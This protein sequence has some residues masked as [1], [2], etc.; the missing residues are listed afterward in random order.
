MAEKFFCR[1]TF[2]CDGNMPIWYTV[3][4]GNEQCADER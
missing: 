3:H 1:F 4:A 2:L